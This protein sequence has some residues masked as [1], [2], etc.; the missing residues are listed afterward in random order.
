MSETE[1]DIVAATTG[2]LVQR[3]SLPNGATVKEG[4]QFIQKNPE[5]FLVASFFDIFLCCD[6]KNGEGERSKC[7]RGEMKVQKKSTLKCL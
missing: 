1:V 3:M 7:E 2:D 4:V 6:F 5:G